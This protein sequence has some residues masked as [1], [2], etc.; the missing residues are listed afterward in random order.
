HGMDGLDEASLGASTLVGELKNGE[1]KEYEIHPEDFGMS[2]V[3]NRAIRVNNREE[4]AQMILQALDN[5]P[6]TARDIVGFNAGLAVYAGN[7]TAT[8]AEGLTLE[9]DTI[10]SVAV[11]AHR[12]P[13]ATPSP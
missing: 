10:D 4:S 2:M 7:K 3:S 11:R 8:L 9:F 5:R 6:G 12:D 1:V 13:S